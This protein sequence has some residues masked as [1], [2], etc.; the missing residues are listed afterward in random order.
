LDLGEKIRND[1][2]QSQK[3]KELKVLIEKVSGNTFS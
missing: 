3:G 2:I 1:F